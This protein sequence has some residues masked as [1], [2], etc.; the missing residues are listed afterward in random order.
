MINR[1]IYAFRSFLLGRYNKAVEA[2]KEAE[3]KTDNPDWETHHNIGESTPE[4]HTTTLVSHESTNSMADTKAYA[5]TLLNNAEKTL[6][7][8]ILECR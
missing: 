5:V 1:C 3:D 8:A 7:Q 4:R 6:K 2:Y